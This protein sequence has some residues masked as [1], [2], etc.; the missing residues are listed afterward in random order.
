MRS[1]LASFLATASLIFAGSFSAA[2]MAQTA[3]AADPAPRIQGKTLD[4]QAFD[5]AAHKG[6]VVL[7]MFWATD[8]AICR[9]KMPELREN[10]KGWSKQP[11]KLVLI[12]V[13][14][15]MS[16]VEAYNAIINASVPMSER[17]TQLWAPDPGYKDNLN[18]Q[19]LIQQR[20]AASL[21]LALILDKKGVVV[22]RY[23]GR[24]PAD[25]WNDIA[26]LL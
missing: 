13:D 7:L 6:K 8:C 15:K 25:V 14:R 1:K 22:K 21:P 20:H 19:S 3:T 5:L 2:S 16:D 26:D 18:T 17:L 12:N 10:A 24:I 23:H 11:F 9:D 4:G